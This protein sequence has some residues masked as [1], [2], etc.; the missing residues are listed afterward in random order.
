MYRVSL[1]CLRTPY[2]GAVTD[3]Q[4]EQPVRIGDRGSFVARGEPIEAEVTQVVVGEYP[5][6]TF[7]PALD[8]PEDDFNH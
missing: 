4:C 3:A 5:L 8:Y 2:R 6:Y 1:R 7:L